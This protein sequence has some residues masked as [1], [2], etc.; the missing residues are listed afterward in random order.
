MMLEDGIAT[1]VIGGSV[2]TPHAYPWQGMLRYYK[3]L[4]CAVTVIS[5]KYV[6]TAGH[7]N[8]MYEQFVVGP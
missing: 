3:K 8:V 2:A 4:F 5:D 7:C 1:R 6:L